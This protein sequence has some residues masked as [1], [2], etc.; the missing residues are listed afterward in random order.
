MT[1]SFD[2]RDGDVTCRGQLALPSGDDPRPAI[3]VFADIG[4]IGEHSIRWATRLADE[5]GYVALAADTYG[6]GWL[7][8]DFAA[9]MPRLS[10]MKA[11][12]AGLARRG[13]AALSALA[14]HPRCN[15]KLGAIGFCFGGTVVLEMARH[16]AAGYVAGVSFHGD[17]AT[18]QP[19]TAPFAT[20]LMVCHGAED[21]LV[22]DAALV[23]FLREMAGVGADCTTIAYTGAV[24][25]F[26][27]RNA[28]GSVLPGLRHHARTEARSWRAMTAHFAEAFG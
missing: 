16:H 24:H 11:D 1:E 9:G 14:A 4:G 12:P 3:A 19:A 23:A 20:S 5:L 15:G 17:V 26:T 7:P 21:P 18:P 6:E 25:S 2:Y 10:A 22:P 8:A 28:D 13:A 27:N